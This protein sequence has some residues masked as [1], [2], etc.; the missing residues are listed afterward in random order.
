MNK[1][2][3]I[4]TMKRWYMPNFFDKSMFDYTKLNDDEIYQIYLDEKNTYGD[5]IDEML[6]ENI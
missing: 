3:I 1:Q 5:E 4:K 6:K 2:N